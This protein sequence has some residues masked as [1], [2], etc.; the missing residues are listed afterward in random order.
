MN[1]IIKIIEKKP[2]ISKIYFL[3]DIFLKNYPKKALKITTQKTNNVF[4]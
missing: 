1:I 3:L 4:Y 2:L